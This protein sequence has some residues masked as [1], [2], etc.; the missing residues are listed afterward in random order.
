MRADLEFLASPPVDGRASLTP[1]AD[2]AAWFLAT[3]MRKAGLQ[4]GDGS[5][6][7]QQFD[8]VALRLDR[9]RSAI[10]VRHGGNEQRFVPAAVFFPDPTRDVD[11][12]LDV[13]FAGY[14]VTAPEFGYDDYAGRGRPRQG[15]ARLRPRAAGRRSGVGVP[16]HRLHA[17]C[18]RL[19]E[20][21]ERAT[22]RRRRDPRRH[23][24]GQHPPNGAQA[25]RPRQRAAA[26]AGVERASHSA[27]EPAG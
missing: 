15:R 7:L 23:R 14:G 19:D 22:A 12:T 18:Q 13:V 17:A 16:W 1:G 4:P 27:R 25:A 11:L 8:L 26:G 6:Y 24:A 21:V 9:D 3:E 2:A 20:N 10:V 5:K